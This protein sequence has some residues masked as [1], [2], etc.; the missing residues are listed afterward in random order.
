M[1]SARE[2]L[3]SAGNILEILEFADRLIFPEIFE[4]AG[5][6]SE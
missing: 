2:F 4:F 6:E 5:R 3:E 1:R